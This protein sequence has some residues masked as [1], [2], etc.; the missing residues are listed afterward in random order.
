MISFKGAKYPK[1]VI[2][3]MVF[4]YVRYGV[5]CRDLEEIMYERDVP[6][7]HNKLNSWGT[8]FSGAIA[9]AELRRKEPCDRS[10]RMNETYM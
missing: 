7:D 5:S 4:F 6:V 9:E 3:F 8:Q 1:D 10:W 2:Q